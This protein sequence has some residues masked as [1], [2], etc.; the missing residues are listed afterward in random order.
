MTQRGNR[1]QAVFFGDGDYEA[2]L[3]LLRQFCPEAGLKVLAYCLMPNHVHLVVV[4]REGDA[5][6]G[7][8]AEAH[9][10]YT[11]RV[12]FGRSGGSRRGVRV[13][14][15]RR[16]GAEIHVLCMSSSARRTESR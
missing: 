11:R 1:G 13:A 7:G 2:Y 8:P 9:R 12:N 6:R 15:G 3:E 10:R 14:R 16:P 4:P 5:L